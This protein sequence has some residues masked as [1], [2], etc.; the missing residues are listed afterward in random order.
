MGR[1]GV[2][3]VAVMTPQAFWDKDGYL[4]EMHPE[5]EGLAKVVF[6]P[7]R[8][9]DYPI[10]NTLVYQPVEVF[11]RYKPFVAAC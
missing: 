9:P 2:A 5:I 6:D 7:A 10:L 1:F 4:Y 11:E 8:E 3:G